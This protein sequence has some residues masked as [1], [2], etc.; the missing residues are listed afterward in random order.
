MIDVIADG[1]RL[2]LYAPSAK[3]ALPAVSFE[4]PREIAGRGGDHL[5]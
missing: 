3:N 1:A 5:R 4:R 2:Q